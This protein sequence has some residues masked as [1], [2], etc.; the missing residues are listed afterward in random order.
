M[1][2]SKGHQIEAY[3]CEIDNSMYYKKLKLNSDKSELPGI[4]S[5]YQPRPLVTSLKVITGSSIAQSSASDCNLGVV[6]DISLTFDKHSAV[7]KSAFYHLRRIA[8]IRSYLSEESTIALIHAFITFRLDNGNAPLYGLPKYQIQ[9]LQSILNCA[10]RLIK[11]LSKFDHISALLFELHWL[12]VEHHVVFEILLLVFKSLNNIA[13][14]YYISD[15]LKQYSH[16]G[17]G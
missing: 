7:C 6:F 14:T 3:A 9:R 11:C 15:L 4:S 13:P 5:R 10:V 17:S 1:P 12:P 8:K 16:S 2:S